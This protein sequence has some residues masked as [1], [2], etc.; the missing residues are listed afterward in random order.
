MGEGTS[1]S[2]KCFVSSLLEKDHTKRPPTSSILSD[3]WIQ[4][5]ADAEWTH[6]PADPQILVEKKPSNLGRHFTGKVKED[7]KVLCVTFGSLCHI[8]GCDRAVPGWMRT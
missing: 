3:A 2:A 5:S 1:D 4:T 7:R 8:T 6:P